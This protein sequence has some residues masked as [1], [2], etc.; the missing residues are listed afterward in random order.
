MMNGKLL[1]SLF[2][3]LL[4]A[5]GAG[6]AALAEDECKKIPITDKKCSGDKDYPVVTINTEGENIKVDPLFVCAVRGA[7]VKFMVFPVG[8]YDLGSVLITP[9]KIVRT[10]PREK[11]NTWLLRTNSPDASKIK[12]GVPHWIEPEDYDY[13]I[14]LADGRCV[15]PRVH[16]EK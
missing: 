11:I 5:V 14:W 2:A 7:E 12:V 9:K 15:D 10:G 6:A 4:L 3:G 1:I 13:N 8:K 16:V